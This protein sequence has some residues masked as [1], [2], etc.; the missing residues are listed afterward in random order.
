MLGVE[1]SK[2]EIINQKKADNESNNRVEGKIA[3][4]QKTGTKI[5]P[6]Q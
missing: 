1:V 6:F 4:S 2:I 3:T 5:P